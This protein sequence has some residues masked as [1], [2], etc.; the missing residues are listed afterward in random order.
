MFGSVSDGS[1]WFSM[2]LYSLDYDCGFKTSMTSMLKKLY[3]N[4][5]VF[6]VFYF[7]IV[8]RGDV[9]VQSVKSGIETVEVVW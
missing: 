5:F 1:V 2:K 6:Y 3:S 7:Y 9:S 8:Q 4:L